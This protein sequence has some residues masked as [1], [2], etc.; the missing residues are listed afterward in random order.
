MQEKE[1]VIVPPSPVDT[2]NFPLITDL[3]FLE[4]FG[5]ESLNRKFFGITPPGIYRGFK[6]ELPGGMV[7]RIGRAG[8]AGTAIVELNNEHCLT[9]QQRHPVDLQVK[10]GFSGFVVLEG[11]YKFGVPTAQVDSASAIEAARILLVTQPEIRPDHVTLYALNV[12]AGTSAL[13]EAML[14]TEHRQ[15]VELAGGSAVDGG[16]F[17][18]TALGQR[19][20]Q[21][22]RGP[23]HKRKDFHLLPGELGYTTDEER[24]AIG[25][26]GRAGGL[27]L[28]ASKWVEAAGKTA[29]PQG[30]YLFQ[31]GGVLTLPDVGFEPGETVYV[32]SPVALTPAGA[33]MLVKTTGDQDKIATSGGPVSEIR[34]QLDEEAAFVRTGTGW[35]CLAGGK[36]GMPVGTIVIFAKRP[37][38]AG[39]LE[40]NGASFNQAMYPT[41]FEHLGTDKLPNFAD[42]YPKM[43][44]SEIELLE[45]RGWVVPSHTHEVTGGAHG[46]SKGTMNITGSVTIDAL[47]GGSNS[48][49]GGLFGFGAFAGLEQKN[50]YVVN[51][52]ANPIGSNYRTVSFDA[53][54]TWT[55][56]TSDEAHTHDVSNYG[57]GD[58]VDPNHIGVIYAIKAAGARING[59]LLDEAGILTELAALRR[60]MAELEGGV[61][62]F[63]TFW[64][65]DRNN[66]P[67]GY[68]PAD[69]QLLSRELFPTVAQKLQGMASR[70]ISDAAWLAD[71]FKRG[72]YTLGDGSTNFRLPDLNGKQSG[73]LGALYLRGD[74]LNSAVADGL[75]QA[76]AI[77]KHTHNFANGFTSP[78]GDF[79]N[80]DVRVPGGAPTTGIDNGAVHVGGVASSNQATA[81]VTVSYNQ[82]GG[83]ETR[84]V[85]VTGCYIIKLFSANNMIGQANAAQLATEVSRLQSEKASAADGV[86]L[87]TVQWWDDRQSLPPGYIPADGQ[88]LTRDMFPT[89]VAQ[90][91]ASP[92]RVISD[93]AWL[94]DSLKRGKYTL[95]DGSTNFRLPDLNG[96]QSGSLG[97]LYLRGD[98]LNSAGADGLIQGDTIRNMTGRIGN[99]QLYPAQTSGGVFVVEPKS[100]T[101]GLS[102]APPATGLGTADF[103]MDVSRQVPTGPENRPVSVTGCYIIKLF[104]SANVVGEGDASQLLAEIAKLQ[105]E[106]ASIDQ[107]YLENPVGIPQYWPL[108]V[109]PDGWICC[110]GQAF[111]KQQC[112][113]LAQAYPS[114]VLPDLRGKFIRSWD[115]GRGV[116]KG[117]VLLSHQSSQNLEHYHQ[118]IA[119]KGSS[120]PAPIATSSQ[121]AKVYQGTAPDMFIRPETGWVGAASGLSTTSSGGS[122][123][124]PDNVSMN[125]IVRRA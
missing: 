85:S 20:I 112:P 80:I 71:P 84:P 69:G 10:A 37:I 19:Q 51:G 48:Q 119:A 89:A 25:G 102:L 38:P 92:S 64:C 54:K 78:S 121:Y 67:A 17:D 57:Q 99:C 108:E 77:K 3:Q 76:D 100:Q 41:L 70:T 104:S 5:S 111:D 23:E 16:T 26:N 72:K 116:D 35:M 58:H 47:I 12:P 98:G 117:R 97:A 44:G 114:G 39:F 42:R 105:A 123:A 65:D 32:R 7:L 52:I 125:S 90:L 66:I 1:F 4:P 30:K 115:N 53:S 13:T 83:P 106:K 43:V 63:T 2:S 86:P 95:G 45:R 50:G 36:D 24:V 93:A 62:L 33:Q 28:D 29:L 49:V 81:S 27:L 74:G 34:M 56:K 22:R 55:G 94:A 75:I 122:E 9:I 88:L 118:D 82:D 40:L 60:D 68:A 124:R 107:L 31:Q 59:G 110:M 18:G 109:P 79:T 87:L 113:R 8:E 6:A 61:P 103:Y 120:L 21:V 11:F 15:D 46:H 14:S 91:K 73:S 96:K 101:N